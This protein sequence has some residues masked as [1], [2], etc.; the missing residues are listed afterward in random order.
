MIT[1]TL[2]P[3]RITEVYLCWDCFPLCFTI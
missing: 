3:G 1:Q 2:S